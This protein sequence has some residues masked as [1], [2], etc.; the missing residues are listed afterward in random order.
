MGN[1]LAIPTLELL[2]G[3]LSGGLLIDTE[4]KKMKGSHT[5]QNLSLTGK[6][7]AMKTSAKFCLIS[8]IVGDCTSF[9]HPWQCFPANP[10]LHV[11]G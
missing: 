4:G 5:R 1:P 8:L 7:Y 11:L 2:D 10:H 6:H 3:R 9:V